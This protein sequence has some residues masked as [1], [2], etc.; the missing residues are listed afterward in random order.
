[1]KKVLIIRFSSFGDIVQAMRVPIS[2]HKRYPQCEIHWLVR[3]DF[4]PLLQDHPQIDR[5][6]SLDKKDG[7]LGL[8][9]II[10]LIRKERYSHIYDA[11][12]NLRSSIILSLLCWQ[13]ASIIRRSKNRI[14]R[15]FLFSLRKNF[16]PKPFIGQ[17]SFLEPLKKWDIQEIPKGKAFFIPENALQ[18]AQDL[19]PD[20]HLRIAAMPSAAWELKRWPVNYW[21]DLLSLDKEEKYEWVFLGGP[22]DLFIDELLSES[23][24]SKVKN[25]RG[26]LSLQESCAILNRCDL[27]ISND[28]GLLHVADQLEKPTLALIGPSA[29]GYPF[30]ETAKAL[31]VDLDCKP[32]SKDGRGKCKNATYQKC[33][34]EVHPQRV[35][36]EVCKILG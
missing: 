3:K 16:F 32:C 13:F 9:R 19:L 2:I 12:N 31:E 1:M 7:I 25:F 34:K 18:K 8:I 6:I 35:Y 15:F 28:T 22:E 14:K 21:Q 11:H 24:H 26:K 17:K 20:S 29:F 5:V 30:S 23:Q 4:A 10:G 27:V 36:E 33:L